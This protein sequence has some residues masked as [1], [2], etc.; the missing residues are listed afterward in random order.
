MLY[1]GTH[2]YI[3]IYSRFHLTAVSGARAVLR[4]AR[5]DSGARTT[6]SGIRGF[7]STK[8]WAK[9]TKR[10]AS[11]GVVMESDLRNVKARRDQAKYEFYKLETLKG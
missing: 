7:C 10:K 4:V 2:T 1:K 11:I 5:A 9:K 8:K 3:Y 6:V